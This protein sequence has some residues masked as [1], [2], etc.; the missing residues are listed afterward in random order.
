[1]VEYICEVCGKQDR[2][3]GFRKP[4]FCSVACKAVG[5]RQVPPVSRE[6]LYEKYTTEGLG[7]PDIAALLNCDPTTILEYLR[8]YDIP[9]RPRG[10][11]EKVQFKKGQPSIF[12]GSMLSEESR[13]KIAAAHKRNN[14]VPYL[15][16][17]KPWMRGR[18][19]TLST[20]WKGGITPERQAVYSSIEWKEAI[21]AVWKRDN[22]TCQR[23]RKHHNT[24]KNRGTFDI[25][26]IVSFEVIELRCEV[27]NLVLL[28]EPC[29]LWVHSAANVR[30]EFLG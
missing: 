2:R 28:C 23:C 30:K 20:N 27:N 14:H 13:Q 5:T 10:S 24:A 8:K 25:H 17:G 3:R 4:R 29:H 22:A 7:C 12:N 21:K 19:G 26:H 18:K 11:N 16:D 6:W 15:K 1:M 9:T